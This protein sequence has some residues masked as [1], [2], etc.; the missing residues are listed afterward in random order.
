MD[1]QNRNRSLSPSM[2]LAMFVAGLVVGLG[3][4]ARVGSE[5]TAGLIIIAV[6]VFVLS[7]LQGIAET[8]RRRVAASELTSCL[9]R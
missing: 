1:D 3:M 7:L 8:R 5:F 2:M 9:F 6:L 4:A